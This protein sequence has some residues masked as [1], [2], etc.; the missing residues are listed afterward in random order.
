[1]GSPSHRSRRAWTTEEYPSS[2][3][4]FSSSTSYTHRLLNMEAADVLCVV[5]G[6]QPQNVPFVSLLDLRWRPSRM[7]CFRHRSVSEGRDRTMQAG[8]GSS[9]C[10][11]MAMYGNIARLSLNILTHWVK[12]CKNR[13]LNMPFSATRNITSIC[14]AEPNISITNSSPCCSGFCD[15]FSVNADE[16]STSSGHQ[17]KYR[18]SGI[19]SLCFVQFYARHSTWSE[20][21][22]TTAPTLTAFRPALTFARYS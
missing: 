10:G 4:S 9:I 7:E 11:W 20:Q 2:G 19:Q 18:I 8:L 5:C 6:L 15:W 14:S 3:L 16:T 17:R 13:V 22:C 1:M 21:A 12:D